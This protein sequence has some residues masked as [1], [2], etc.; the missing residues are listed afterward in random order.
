MSEGEGDALLVLRFLGAVIAAV[1]FYSAGQEMRDI[2]S[3]SGDSIAEAFYHA[4]G[5]F[6]WG[7]AILS[8]ALGI[9]G[10]LLKAIAGLLKLFTGPPQS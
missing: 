7:M 3:I 1:V 10:G 9:S 4:V 5:L 6:S 2:T 8:L